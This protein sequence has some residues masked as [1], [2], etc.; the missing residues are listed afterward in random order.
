[1][2]EFLGIVVFVSSLFAHQ[3]GIL[4]MPESQHRFSILSYILF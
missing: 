1:L 3:L 2:S 4:K